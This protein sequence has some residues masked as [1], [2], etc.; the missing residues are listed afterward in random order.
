MKVYHIV[1]KDVGILEIFTTKEQLNTYINKWGYK[2]IVVN[3]IN[4][5][6][7][8]L[9]QMELDDMLSSGIDGIYC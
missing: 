9:K 5:T 1:H 7:A 3:E 6:K 2:D 4:Y 8:E